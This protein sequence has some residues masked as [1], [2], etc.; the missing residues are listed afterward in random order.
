MKP[1]RPLQSL[2]VK[3]SIKI[4]GKKTN[5]SLE[6]QFWGALKEIVK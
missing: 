3:R 5:I 6:D 4:A 1:G 2:V